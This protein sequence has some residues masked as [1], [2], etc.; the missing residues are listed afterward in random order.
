VWTF[1]F[2]GY[3][4]GSLLTG[5]VFQPRVRTAA[6]K[7]VFLFFTICLTGVRIMRGILHFLQLLATLNNAT[8]CRAEISIYFHRTENTEV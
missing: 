6:A 4:V 7:L 5:L 1:G 8:F 3:L 2:L